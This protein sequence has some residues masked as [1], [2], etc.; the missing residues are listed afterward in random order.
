MG[1][2]HLAR[3]SPREYA[4]ESGILAALQSNAPTSPFG[5]E[6][7]NGN[8]PESALGALMSSRSDNRYGILGPGH[9]VAG[10]GRGGG[11]TGQGTIGLGNLGTIG[12]GGGGGAARASP[13]KLRGRRATPSKTLRQG[14]AEVRGSLSREVVSRYVRRHRNE[15]RYCYQ[16]RLDS[17]PELRGRV[18]VRFV[19]SPGGAVSSSAVASSTLGDPETEQCVARAIQRI[20]FPQP[21]GGGVVVVT[22]PFQFEPGD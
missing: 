14:R 20:A 6:T 10:S 15:I 19:I 21:E 9:G 1:S 8:D 13:T 17:R 3:E 2:V 22:L 12:H 4:S 7:A 18:V 5:V 16:R 11:G